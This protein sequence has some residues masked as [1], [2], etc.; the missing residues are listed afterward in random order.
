MGQSANNNPPKHETGQ[1]VTDGHVHGGSSG[2]PFWLSSSPSQMYFCCISICLPAS[3]ILG[4]SIKSWDGM[5]FCC[6]FNKGCCRVLVCKLVF[7]VTELCG[8]RK[9][10]KG[11]GK[12]AFIKGLGWGELL[13]HL[14]VLPTSWLQVWQTQTQKLNHCCCESFNLL[15]C[16]FRAIARASEPAKP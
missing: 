7:N 14:P 12:T 5:S 15:F 6:C 3:I 9:L 2:H 4:P 1:A 16:P 10:M 8:T 13:G 11:N